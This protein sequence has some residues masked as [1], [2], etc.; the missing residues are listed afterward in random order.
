M[1]S[2]IMRLRGSNEWDVARNLEKKFW[3]PASRW[4]ADF[5]HA[6]ACRDCVMCGFC[7]AFRMALLAMREQDL[8]SIVGRFL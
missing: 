3:S 5:S 8:T 2:Y 4:C 6:I 1:N 7:F